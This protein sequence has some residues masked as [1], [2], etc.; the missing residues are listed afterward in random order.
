MELSPSNCSR[1]TSSFGLGFGAFHTNQAD[2][3][4]A[5]VNSSATNMAIL[6]NRRNVNGKSVS[7]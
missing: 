7:S 5:S 4:A 1:G 2:A 6:G 3:T